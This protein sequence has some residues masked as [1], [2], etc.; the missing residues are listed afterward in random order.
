[1][2]IMYND[3]M[4]SKQLK[5]LFVTLDDIRH[6]DDTGL[7]F[8][9]AKELCPVVGYS[10][11]ES[12]KPIIEKAKTACLNSSGSLGKN[13]IEKENDDIQLSRYACY[14]IAVNGDPSKQEI[15][16]AQAYFVSQ[17]R[18]LE[19]LEKKMEEYTRLETRDKLK[20]TEKEFATLAFSNG[21]DGRGI[22]VIRSAGD[23]KLFGGKNTKELKEQM[24][25][26]SDKPLADFL[27]NVTLKAKDLA[28]AMTN[29][30][31]KSKGLRG[32]HPIL[33]EHESN[34]TNVRKALTESGIFPEELP[35]AEDITQIEKRHKQEL[36]DL[37]EKQRKELEQKTLF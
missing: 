28:T 26:I 6:T 17:T 36:E 20:I 27:P 11:W 29:E 32:I 14:L 33:D 22:A 21:V 13:F 35:P 2:Q 9:Y 10:K 1:M 5:M 8:W 30:N 12:F 23:K 24:G 7:D 15:S 4:E 34:N 37:K 16:F 3:D 31:L 19:V 18:R 25:I